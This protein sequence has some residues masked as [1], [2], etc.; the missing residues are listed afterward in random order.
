MNKPQLKNKLYGE[1]FEYSISRKLGKVIREREFDINDLEG[2]ASKR[3][4]EVVNAFIPSLSIDDVSFEYPEVLKWCKG[5]RLLPEIGSLI[6]VKRK[7]KFFS[8]LSECVA[9]NPPD[10]LVSFLKKCSD[11]FNS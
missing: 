4:T 11:D 10:H 8:V 6:G 7:R 1:Y 2:D 5:K 9:R 3:I